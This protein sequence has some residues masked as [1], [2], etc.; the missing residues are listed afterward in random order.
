MGTT[1]S[2]TPPPMLPISLVL[3]GSQRDFQQRFRS[4]LHEHVPEPAEAGSLSR[5]AEME[6]RRSWQRVLLAHG[7]A[8]VTW[9]KEYGGIGADPISQFLY[10]EELALAGAPDPPNRP[11]SIL[12]GPT[13]IHHAD[14]RIKQRYLRRILAAD[15]IWCQCFSEPDA[16]SDL[17]AI[18]TTAVVDGDCFRINGQKTWVTQGDLA[19]HSVVLCRTGDRS[20]RHRTL[21][22]LLVALDQPGVE[23]RPILQ[24]TGETEFSEIFF[25]GATTPVDHVV[26]GVDGGWA[27]AMYMLEFERSDRTFTDHFPL[28]RSLDATR[29]SLLAAAGTVEARRSGELW[30]ELARLWARAHVLREMN[31]SI[32]VRRQDGQPIGASSSPVKVYWAELTQAV[33]RLRYELTGLTDGIEHGDVRGYLRSRMSTVHAGTIDIQR[34][35][36]AERVLGLPRADNK[37]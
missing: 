27:A 1:A 13:L 2:A 18:R 20:A 26:G 6:S 9:P 29:A 12:L 21:S 36:I 15:D 28:L 3:E 10:Y 4:W 35:I 7:W 33:A 19:T 34:S 17:A 16:G 25:D 37:R 23:V 31:L 8:G 5:L 24:P 14:E 30:N 11:G 32:A 22:L